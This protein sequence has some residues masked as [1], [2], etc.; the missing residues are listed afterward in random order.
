MEAILAPQET[1][2]V[3]TI[4]FGIH[5]HHTQKIFPIKVVDINNSH[6]LYQ[7]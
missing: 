5:I 2:I 7:T 4:F 1:E 3:V 6:I